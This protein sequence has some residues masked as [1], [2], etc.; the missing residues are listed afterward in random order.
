MMNQARLKMGYCQITWPQ[1]G[2]G[3]SNIFEQDGSVPTWE[4]LASLLVSP[5]LGKSSSSMADSRCKDCRSRVGGFA[6][7]IQGWLLFGVG[8]RGV[9]RLWALSPPGPWGCIV[10]G[11]STKMRGTCVFWGVES[12]LIRPFLTGE[13]RRSQRV[14]RDD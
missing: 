6:H 14:S 3:D 12:S 1:S 13:P 2:L 8:G 11:T 9:I 7:G 10:S 5:A 4:F